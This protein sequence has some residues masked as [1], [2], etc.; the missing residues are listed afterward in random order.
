MYKTSRVLS[1]NCAFLT[2]FMKRAGLNENLSTLTE[3][4]LGIC[5]GGKCGTNLNRNHYSLPTI[6]GLEKAE[7]SLIQ[8]V[9]KILNAHISTEF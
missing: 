4:Y 3:P 5:G 1:V 6:P 8:N 9:L 7:Q 2:K